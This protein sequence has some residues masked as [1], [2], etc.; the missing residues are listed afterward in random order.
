MKHSLSSQQFSSVFKSSFVVNTPHIVY[1]VLKSDKSNQEGLG[2]VIS[3]KLGSSVTRNLFK[4]FLRGL[5]FDAFVKNNVKIA[6]IILPKRI[7]LKKEEIV[8][9]FELF[10]KSI[11]LKE[12]LLQL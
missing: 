1:R 3:K 12:F 5:Y 2:F 7:K 6:M 9:S 10:K 4:R 8:E 11:W